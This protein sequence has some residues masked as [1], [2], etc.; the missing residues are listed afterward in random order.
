MKKGTALMAVLVMLLIVAGCGK[1]EDTAAIQSND[2][3]TI[4]KAELDVL[5]NRDKTS[6]AKEDPTELVDGEADI[7]EPVKYD[8]KD[9]ITA[10]S[11]DSGLLQIDDMILQYGA[12]FS[13][14]DKAIQESEC[15]YVAEDYNLSSV[16]PAGETVAIRYY[17]NDEYHFMLRMENQESETIE[18]KDCVVYEIYAKE[19]ETES[20]YYAGFNND[21]MT[22]TTVK[23]IMG[24]YEPEKEILGSGKNSNKEL[25]IMY[26]VPFQEEEIHIYFIF[27]GVTNDL[28]SFVVSSWKLNDVAWPW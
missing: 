14:I 4:A 12:K 10:A 18:L 28:I 26:T 3:S 19:K 1:Q 20:A 25:G 21:K 8:C 23:E 11:P 16:V 22:Y 9:E 17:R 13:E 24:D 2:D 5:V 7:D 27:D 15:T 6:E